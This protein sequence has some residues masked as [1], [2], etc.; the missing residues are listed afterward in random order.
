MASPR[1]KHVI[2]EFPVLIED[3]E[4]AEITS[5]VNADASDRDGGAESFGVKGRN[6]GIKVDLVGA[7]WTL[8]TS[9]TRFGGTRRSF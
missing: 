2:A 3:D 4:C 6:K 8:S 5:W 1:F 9:A 7:V